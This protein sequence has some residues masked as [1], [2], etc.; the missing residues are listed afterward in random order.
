M[1]IEIGPITHGDIPGAARCIQE[2]F[3]DD[4]YNNWV[5]DKSKVCRQPL[6]AC[7]QWACVHNVRAQFNP[8]RNIGSLTLRCE[9]GIRNALFY[10]AKD[11]SSPSPDKVLGIAMWTPPI[12]AARPPTW[13]ATLDTW[14]LWFRQGL[15]NIRFMGRGGLRVNRYWIWKARQAEAQKELWTDEQGYYFCNIVTVLPGEQ[16]RGIGRKLMQA[17]M[18]HADKEDRKCYL[19]S[20]RL[21]PNVAIYEKMGFR[22]V[23]EMRCEDGVE[24]EGCDVSDRLR[25]AERGSALVCL[26]TLIAI[27]H[28]SRSKPSTLTTST[29]EVGRSSTSGLG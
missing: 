5:F 29:P 27:L 6:P 10:V 16:G 22:L 9:W 28:D 1:Q 25:K 21:V 2:A 18:D 23:R 4:P 11:P 17:A 24:G 7:C 15:L 12:P 3:A 13:S 20:S 26:L 19:E 14:A 8:E